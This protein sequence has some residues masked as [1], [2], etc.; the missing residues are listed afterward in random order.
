M[1]KFTLI[2][3]LLLLPTSLYAGGV[4]MMG[5]GAEAAAPPAGGDLLAETFTGASSGTTCP[6]G[7]GTFLSAAWTCNGTGNTYVLADFD[8]SAY[9]GTFSGHGLRILTEAQW[10]DIPYAQWTDGSDHATVYITFD[11]RVVSETLGNEEGSPFVTLLNS[12]AGSSFIGLVRQSA[13][14]QLTLQFYD[15][16]F[17]WSDGIINISTGTNYK[18][19]IRLTDGAG[20]TDTIQVTVDSTVVLNLTGETLTNGTFR[21]LRLG[22]DNA[23]F[24]VDTVFDNINVDSAAWK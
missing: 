21:T 18:V 15:P 24:L 22:T 6:A 11:L 14:G 4:M 5:G 20:G 2:L 12:A 8:V 13:A 1:K 9:G 3:C 19:K 17:S 10:S 16:G 23:D 7:T